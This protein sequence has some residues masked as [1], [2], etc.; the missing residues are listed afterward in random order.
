MGLFEPLWKTENPEKLGEAVAS[1]RNVT[2]PK[3]LREIAVGAPFSE[4]QCAAVMNLTDEHILREIVKTETVSFQARKEAV[5]RISDERI[6]AEIAVM[7]S[8]YPADG[9]A[10]ARLTDPELLKRVAM[11]EQGWEQSKAVYRINDQ[12]TLV[13]IALHAEKGEARKTATRCITSLDAL[14]DLM[15]NSEE[16]FVRNE[17]FRCFDEKLDSGA[18]F[19]PSRQKRYLDMILNVIHMD[20]PVSLAHF[21]DRKDLERVYLH[22]KREDLRAE[23]F[24]R[25]T[26]GKLNSRPGLR[27]VWRLA[28]RNYIRTSAQSSNPWKTTLQNITTRILNSHDP[29]LLVEC[30]E[31]AGSGPDLAAAFLKELFGDRFRDEAGIDMIRDE[32]VAA[33][34]TNL[35]TYAA[36]NRAHDMQYC[37]MRLAEAVPAEAGEHK[38]YRRFLKRVR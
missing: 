36:A 21:S 20:D 12:D 25:L 29:G 37:L 4:V 8:C 22:A 19:T 6:L 26:A 11:S 27:E 5:A 18:E 7:R 33:Y 31:E 38:W 3:K 15:E 24:S 1:V 13:E 17:A 14:L 9:E 28:G 10:I 34:L 30:I 35:E 2:D 23:A 16:R 32:G